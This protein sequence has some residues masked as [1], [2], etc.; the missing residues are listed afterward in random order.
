MTRTR[1]WAHPLTAIPPWPGF[2]KDKD[3]GIRTRVWLN[4]LNLRP[5][6]LA[7][8][9]NLLEGSLPGQSIGDGFKFS[10]ALAPYTG[11]ARHWPAPLEVAAL[12]HAYPPN[13]RAGLSHALKNICTMNP[14]FD[15]ACSLKSR[16]RAVPGSLGTSTRNRRGS[17]PAGNRLE[18]F[19]LRSPKARPWRPDL[20][21]Q[22]L[23][24]HWQPFADYLN[25]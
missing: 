10:S 17:L 12:T 23:S 19:G 15:V 18:R 1:R 21:A 11:G 13:K 20:S 16:A 5:D 7:S 9:K 24:T 25:W 6:G 3:R 14:G 2:P 4:L 22:F 8:A